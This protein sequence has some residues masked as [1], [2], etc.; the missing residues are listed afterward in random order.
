MSRL[1]TV[2]PLT[3]ASKVLRL[4]LVVRLQRLGL[5]QEQYPPPL[6]KRQHKPL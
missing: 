6:A 5:L 3:S 2:N 1:W 4:L